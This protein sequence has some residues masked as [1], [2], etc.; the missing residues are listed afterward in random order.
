[1]EMIGDNAD[2]KS[3]RLYKTRGGRGGGLATIHTGNGRDYKK[4][5]A[6]EGGGSL[7]IQRGEDRRQ[8]KEERQR[9]YK[10]RGGQEGEHLL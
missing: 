4:Q 5:A 1:M 2:R 9:L 10:S 3:R 7:A 6:A 8:Y